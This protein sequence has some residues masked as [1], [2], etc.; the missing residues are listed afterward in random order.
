MKIEE[1]IIYVIAKRN[2]GMTTDQIAEAI[3]RSGLYMRKDNQ[4][5]TGKQVYAV[6]SRFPAIFTKEAGRI[7]L[8]I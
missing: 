2:G 5:V 1:A 6:V 3:N 4:P 7:M 8:L